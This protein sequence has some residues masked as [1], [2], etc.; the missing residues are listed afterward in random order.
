MVRSCPGLA[1]A[2]RHAKQA[3]EYF[4]FFY[5]V[6]GLYFIRAS[7]RARAHSVAK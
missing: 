3:G 4:L 6:C 1:V 7:L 2:I 5:S